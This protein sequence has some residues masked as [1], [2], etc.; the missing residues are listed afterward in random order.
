MDGSGV[1]KWN[2]LMAWGLFHKVGEWKAQVCYPWNEGNSGFSVSLR[3]L[4]KVQ[5]E[6]KE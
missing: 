6:K 3:E 2:H 1:L 5:P 4:Q